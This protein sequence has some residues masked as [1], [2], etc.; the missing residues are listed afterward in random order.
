M[1]MGNLVSDLLERFKL[2]GGQRL[3]K[4]IIIGAGIL[5]LLL[6]VFISNKQGKKSVSYSKVSL[7][8]IDAKKPKKGLNYEFIKFDTV[9]IPSFAP[10]ENAFM[11]Q[12]PA[13]QTLPLTESNRQYRN[14]P[15]SSPK[16]AISTASKV[17]PLLSPETSFSQTSQANKNPNMIV[18]NN[19]AENSVSSNGSP[20]TYAGRQSALVKVVLPNR[21]PVANGSLVEA[22]II[23]E[24]K[25]GN[26]LLPR[27]T[28]LLGVASLF[29]RRVDIELREI[30]IND[31]SRTGGGRAYDLKRLQG[32][33]YS[34]INSE[35]KRVLFEEL[36][37]AV[38]GVPV[39]GRVANRA[40]MYDNLNQDVAELE[41]GLEF[42]FLIES[43][44]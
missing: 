16:P 29:N 4:I 14:A 26:V 21:T 32:L 5:F 15:Q 8:P 20:A 24:A 27:R 7:M 36:R 40:T 23:H 30:V 6:L 39:V 41:E 18:M 22:R 43:I 44:Y 13:I 37:D 2:A 42:Y 33:P 11:E 17:E 38:A 31:V 9:K 34:P 28:K 35:A 10:A 25:W 19:M 1:D 12:S 3:K